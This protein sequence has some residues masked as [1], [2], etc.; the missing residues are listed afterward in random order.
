MCECYWG[1][2]VGEIQLQAARE[3]A[4]WATDQSEPGFRPSRHFPSP[5]PPPNPRPAVKKRV[6]FCGVGGRGN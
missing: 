5:P 1:A 3:S 6:Y 4:G 2:T